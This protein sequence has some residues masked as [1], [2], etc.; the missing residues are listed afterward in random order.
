MS[1]VKS[2]LLALATVLF[3]AGVVGVFLTKH[4]IAFLNGNVDVVCAIGLA[5]NLCS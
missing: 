1:L 3:V 5:L 2:I 4:D